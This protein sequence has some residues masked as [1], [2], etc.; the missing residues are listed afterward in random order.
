MSEKGKFS[1][2][3]RIW[4]SATQARD[5]HLALMFALATTAFVEGWE[6]LRPHIASGKQDFKQDLP[7]GCEPG[8]TAAPTQ[9][10]AV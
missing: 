10:D 4:D 3:A 7:S 2:Y 6:A 8:E 9:A 1:D 5:I